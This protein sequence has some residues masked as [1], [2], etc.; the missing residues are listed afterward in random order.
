MRRLK[1]YV[2]PLL[3]RV[4]DVAAMIGFS[5]SKTYGMIREGG[6]PHIVVEG[7]IRVWRGGVLALVERRGRRA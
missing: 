2:E 7:Q 3:Y 6:I 1:R 5:R 4:S